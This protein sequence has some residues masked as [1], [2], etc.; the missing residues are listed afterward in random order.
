M[1]LCDRSQSL[2]VGYTCNYDHAP[3]KLR[4]AFYSLVRMRWR[5]W[6]EDVNIQDLQMAAQGRDAPTARPPL[7]TFR[8]SVPTA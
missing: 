3:P 8:G 4:E 5:Y 6:D 7:R 1:R 2:A